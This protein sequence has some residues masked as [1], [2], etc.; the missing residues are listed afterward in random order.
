MNEDIM[1]QVNMN[2]FIKS[3]NKND[4]IIVRKNNAWIGIS[5]E[6]YLKEVYE[7]LNKVKDENKQLELQMKG[8]IKEFEIVKNELNTK[9][10]N[11]ESVLIDYGF[12]LMRGGK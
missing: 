2:K 8:V 3:T 4:V 11:F 12:N 9:I 7:E 1:L 10:A 5:K 6:E